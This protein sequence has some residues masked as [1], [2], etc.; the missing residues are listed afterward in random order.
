MPYCTK[1][2]AE[3]RPNARFCHKCGA[4]VRV[5]TT[6]KGV[7]IEERVFGG[8]EE[9][10][11]YVV[12]S[13]GISRATLNILAFVGIFVFGWLMLVN[14]NILGR[15]NL[16]L[17]YFVPTIALAILF[18]PLAIFVYIVGWIHANV[19]LS[20]YKTAAKHRI[21][22]IDQKTMVETNDILEKG[23][24]LHKVLGDREQSLY[25]LTSALKMPGGDP[26]LLRLAGRVMS[27]HKR[28]REASEFFNRALAGAKDEALIK[29]IM[30]D[31]A[32]IR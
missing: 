26:Q 21:I 17:L 3:L 24:L 6:L 20:R 13:P 11:N 5:A 32:S 7:K 19:I 28:Y 22:S 15:R 1:C 12:K 25:V 4:E 31:M 10:R 30:K 8:N 2:G 18:W 14:F 9:L 27:K 29:R 16:G 23:V